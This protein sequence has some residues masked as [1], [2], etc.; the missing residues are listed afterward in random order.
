MCSY[1]YY[2]STT[3]WTQKTGC[4]ASDGASNYQ[5]GTSLQLT[6]NGDT[7]I[8]GAPGATVGS[9]AGA[10]QVRYCWLMCWPGEV[11]DTVQMYTFKCTTGTCSQLGSPYSIIT[12]AG[13]T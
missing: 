5:F 12:T 7:V 3:T 13:Q 6:S 10:G 8:I 9:L 4:V 11:M 2:R 1:V